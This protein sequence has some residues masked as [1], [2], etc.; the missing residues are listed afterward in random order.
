VIN[1]IN[2]TT[3]AHEEGDFKCEIGDSKQADFFPQYKLKRWDNEVNFSARLIGAGLGVHVCKN[4]IVSWESSK[5]TT[6][7]KSDKDGFDF[8]VILK[9]KPATNIINFSVQSKGLKAAKQLKLTPKQISDGDNRPENIIDSYA[10]YH[11]ANR[12]NKYMSGKAFHIFRVKAVDFLGKWTWCDQGLN[13]KTGVMM[14]I[15][16]QA[17]LD[18]ATYPVTVK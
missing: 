15:I 5:I 11:V 16:P 7:F 6:Q 18:S 3:Y 9:E 8:S 4:D 17:F 12:D 14:R 10:V 13:L 1:E 2:S